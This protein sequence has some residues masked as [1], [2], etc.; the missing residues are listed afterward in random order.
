[1]GVME[2]LRRRGTAAVL[3][4]LVLAAMLVL[5]GTLLQP[6]VAADSSTRA[7]ADQSQKKSAKPKLSSSKNTIYKGQTKVLKVKNT[8][9][10]VKWKSSNK[11]VATVNSY[12]Q[13]TG[14]KKGK[15][16]ITAT[17]NGKKLKCKVTV[18]ELSKAQREKVAKQYAKKIVKK[19]TSSKMTRLEK[20]HAL[21]LYLTNTTYTQLNQSESAYKK[22]Y[23]NEAYGAL[24][25]GQAACSGFC[26]AYTMLCKQAGIP[27]RHVNASKWTHQWNE[28]KI[29]KKWYEVD[30]QGH[31]VE[32]TTEKIRPFVEAQ[33][34]PYSD[35]EVCSS[36]NKIFKGSLWD[37]Y[38]QSPK[39][40]KRPEGQS[41]V[42]NG[43]HTLGWDSCPT[44]TKFTTK[45]INAIRV[46]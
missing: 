33:F 19:Y 22:N 30:A 5:G 46:F 1:M 23:G 14:K 26:R 32:Y 44:C 9:G 10:N 6:I 40:D 29:G 2:A 11:K 3:M 35:K 34:P 43:S 7:F 17:V 16:T 31:R 8:S 21:F 41:W 36:C 20:A 13:V 42:V 25:S 24:V 38:R 28:I 12:G 39:C 37:H 4:A 18:K 45:R 27:V 15:A